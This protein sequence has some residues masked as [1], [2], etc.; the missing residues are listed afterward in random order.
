MAIS[1]QSRPRP[2]CH[3]RSALYTHPTPTGASRGGP[4][5]SAWS[6]PTWGGGP[7]RERNRQHDGHAVGPFPPRTRASEA[8]ENLESKTVPDQTAR[9]SH[10]SAHRGRTD[11]PTDGPVTDSS[12]RCC[13]AHARGAALSR[14]RWREVGSVMAFSQV[15]CR[16]SRWNAWQHKLSKVAGGSEQRTL[17]D[18]ARWAPYSCR[19]T[20]ALTD[21]CRGSVRSQCAIETGSSWTDDSG[22]LKYAYCRVHMIERSYRRQR[23]K[24]TAILSTSSLCLSA[25]HQILY[26]S[27]SSVP[28]DQL[29]S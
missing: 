18:G 6:G 5:G 16:L 21:T 14:R 20:Q 19:Q 25:A 3:T 10:L 26:A 9:D 4:R 22:H 1:L 13:T 8:D 29:A 27:R 12:A 2:P 15:P 11:F 7:R 24:D 28:E 23:I 17:A